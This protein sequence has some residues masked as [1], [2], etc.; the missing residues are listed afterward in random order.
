MRASSYPQIAGSGT[1]LK[2]CA[3]GKPLD[4]TVKHGQNNPLRGWEITQVVEGQVAD[5]L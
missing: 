3:A 2:T 5:S 1:H 4:G